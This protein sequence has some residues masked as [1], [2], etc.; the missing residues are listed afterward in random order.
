MNLHLKVHDDS[1]G[2][3]CDVCLKVFVS[4][5]VLI[6]HYR[7]HTGETPFAC[8]I[9]DRNFAQ[10]IHLT[11]HQATHREIKSFKCSICPEGRF[12]KTKVG[13]S[14]HMVFHFEPKFACRHCDYKSHLKANLN[15]HKKIHD[16]K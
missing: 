7:I 12:F 3:K 15:R 6:R 11:Q 13:L 2:F 10:K 14:N 4:K 1:K 9:C 16:K 8:Q 5:S